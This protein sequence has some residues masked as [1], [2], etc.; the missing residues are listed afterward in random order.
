MFG[1]Q[2]RQ[3]LQHPTLATRLAATWPE[4]GS[5]NDEGKHYLPQ[6]EKEEAFPHVFFLFSIH[7]GLVFSLFQIYGNS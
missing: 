6:P 1:V 7:K 4:L 2:I 5:S 3:M